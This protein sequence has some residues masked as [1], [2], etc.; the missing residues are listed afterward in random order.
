MVMNHNIEAHES[1]SGRNASE[2]GES[3]HHIH[4]EV[5]AEQHAA[6]GGHH[7]HHVAA[8]TEHLVKEGTLP[9]VQIHE[10]VHEGAV[11]TALHGSTT[12]DN[13]QDAGT[14]SP[15]HTA[16][17]V[18]EV[19]PSTGSTGTATR[20]GTSEQQAIANTAV[21]CAGQSEW[22]KGSGLSGPDLGCAASDSAVL[23]KAGVYGG[24]QDSVVGLEKDLV[25]KGWT[26]ESKPQPGDVVAGYRVGDP[27]Q[28]TG[29]GA[30]TGIVGSDGN[31]YSN[32]SSTGKWTNDGSVDQFIASNGFVQTH[33]LRAPGGTA[34]A[35]IA[36]NDKGAGTSPPPGRDTGSGSGDGSSGGSGSGGGNGGSGGGDGGDSGSAPRSA[37]GSSAG[38]QSDYSGSVGSDT[39][40]SSSGASG[41]DASAG[42]IPGMGQLSPG[43]QATA[44]ELISIFMKQYGMSAAGAAAVVGNLVQENGLKTE[45][46]AGGLGLAQ[47]IGARA[48]NLKA[49][50]AEHGLSPTSKEAQV[51]F[52]V[53]EL[54]TD[55]P[56]LLAELKTTN[57]PKQAA[58][59]F[60]QQFER[61]GN[62]QNSKR[63]AYA[64][65]ALD[66]FKTGSNS[67]LA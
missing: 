64:V 35:P 41:G 25:A 24:N 33:F 61:P 31:V 53:K 59:D 22:N 7:H 55:Y 6:S 36:N 58:L 23:R 11:R 15:K 56:G 40:S 48:D 8:N 28:S 65:A 12:A 14:A 4:S 43:E 29:G 26:V 1:R 16:K 67:A 32:D 46:N 60:S 66:N 34:D 20:G 30:H 2:S 52:L 13:D 45:E 54:K 19:T 39:G 50:A 63:E 18:A 27:D 10:G 42:Q 37:S 17:T 9:S 49:F 62:P 5:R 38:G 21:A 47:W 3:N 57:D 44:N 51:G